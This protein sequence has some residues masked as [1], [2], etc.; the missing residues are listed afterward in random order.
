[1]LGEETSLKAKKRSKGSTTRRHH[2]MGWW[3]DPWK[4]WLHACGHTGTQPHTDP[5]FSLQKK[6]KS[7]TSARANVSC[8]R[9]SS[10][11]KTWIPTHPPSHSHHYLWPTQRW[12]KLQ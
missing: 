12:R 7:L 1:M 6:Q 4:E 5:S 10:E 9:N 11:P 2:K 3:Q 8:S